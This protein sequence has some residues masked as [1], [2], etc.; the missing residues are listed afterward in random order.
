MSLFTRYGGYGWD[1]LEVCDRCLQDKATR[2]L[3][4]SADGRKLHCAG[5]IADICHA[6]ALNPAFDKPPLGGILAN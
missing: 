4:W 1:P 6:A 3:R 5:C 2:D